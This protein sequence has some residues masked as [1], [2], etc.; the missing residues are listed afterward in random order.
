MG[1]RADFYVG[2]G[3]RAEWIGSMAF[4]G[5]PEGIPATVL[6]SITEASFRV[7]VAE[8]LAARDDAS[9][10]ETGWPWPWE[11]SATTD[12]A[13]AF[14]GRT[15]YVSCFGRGWRSIEEVQAVRGTDEAED[16][17]EGP[18]TAVFPRMGDGTGGSAPAGSKRSGLLVLTIPRRLRG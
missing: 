15:V 10:P 8:M 4:D 5:Y 14:E 18:K 11:T 17:W 6:Q 9:A 3:E 1:T 16:L 12:F 7:T 13:Y 2:R